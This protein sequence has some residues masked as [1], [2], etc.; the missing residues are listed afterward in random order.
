MKQT[1]THKTYA[2]LDNAFAYFNKRLFVDRLPHCLIHGAT[3]SM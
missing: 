1:P 2:S 3:A